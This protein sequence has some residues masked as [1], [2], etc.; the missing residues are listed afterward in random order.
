MNNR[1]RYFFWDTHI[2][3]SREQH[4]FFRTSHDEKCINRLVLKHQNVP[5]TSLKT[6]ESNTVHYSLHISL[7]PVWYFI[8][9]KASILFHYY[10]CTA[11]GVLPQMSNTG[12]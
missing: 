9:A 4:Y 7:F 2:T 10:F 8:R 5:F 11:S 1:R 3:L 12:E 6:L